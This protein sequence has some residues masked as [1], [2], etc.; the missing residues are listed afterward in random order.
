M[1]PEL[2]PERVS[3]LHH[4]GPVLVWVSV[5]FVGALR[6]RMIIRLTFATPLVRAFEICIVM[7][8]FALTYKVTL[9]IRFFCHHFIPIGVFDSFLI[10]TVLIFAV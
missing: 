9:I 8:L 5:I 7:F 6:I 3:A 2:V 4:L 1:V 10:E